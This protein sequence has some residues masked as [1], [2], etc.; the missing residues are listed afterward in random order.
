MQRGPTGQKDAQMNANGW[1]RRAAFA[2]VGALAVTAGA[3]APAMAA[4]SADLGVNQAY[5]AGGATSAEYGDSLTFTFGAKNFG[6]ATAD[7]S[8]NLVTIRGI[9]LDALQCVLRSGF[10]INPDGHN[11]ETG[12]TK[13]GQSGGHLVLTGTV[14]G[15][16]NVVVKA[17]VTDLNGSTDPNT[18]N[19][20]RTLRVALV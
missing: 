4:V 9:K 20:C 13:A 2:C 6:P 5:V 1:A 11:C 19:N 18:A 10:V 7:V 12:L 14:T 8:I 16:S 17:C 3:V 15:T